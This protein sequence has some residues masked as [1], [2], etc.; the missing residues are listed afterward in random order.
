MAKE[1]KLVELTEDEKQGLNR[2]E[3]E[4]LSCSKCIASDNDE[5]CDTLPRCFG[6]TIYFIEVKNDK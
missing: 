6:V 5:L 4:E 2:Q 1:Y 3:L